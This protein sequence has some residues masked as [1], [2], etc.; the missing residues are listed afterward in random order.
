MTV[1]EIMSQMINASRVRRRGNVT[2]RSASENSGVVNAFRIGDPIHKM[3]DFMNKDGYVVMKGFLNESNTLERK[4]K[5][6]VYRSHIR[7]KLR[8]D[9]I[10]KLSYVPSVFLHTL[11]NNDDFD[12]LRSVPVECVSGLEEANLISNQILMENMNWLR[13]RERSYQTQFHCDFQECI[14]EALAYAELKGGEYRRFTRELFDSM[15]KHKNRSEEKLK[16]C[17][18]PLYNL[19]TVID[20]KNDNSRIRIYPGS[21]LIG[22]LNLKKGTLKK[23]IAIE[24]DDGDVLLMHWLLYHE[25]TEERNSNGEERCSIDFRG[26]FEI[27]ENF[28][29]DEDDNYSTL[30]SLSST[31]SIISNKDSLEESLVSITN[32]EITRKSNKRF[33]VGRMGGVSEFQKTILQHLQ[34]IK[35]NQN[36]LKVR[37]D[38]IEEELERSNETRIAG[39]INDSIK[40]VRISCSKTEY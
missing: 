26:C 31:A 2:Y 24:L 5:V 33:K 12:L 10:K 17:Q 6:E 35:T 4:S 3:Q 16:H 22:K 13:L 28:M 19:L 11:P 7:E 8:L 20:P 1:L 15:L 37:L 40:G 29:A 27:D 14:D 9:K 32:N 39:S 38:K 30:S 36:S 18:W 25:A 21:H 23:K 34:D